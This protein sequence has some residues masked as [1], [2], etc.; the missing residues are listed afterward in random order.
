MPT[1]LP[2]PMQIPGDGHETL[3]KTLSPALLGFGALW[4][5]QVDP[6]HVATSGTDPTDP[7][8]VNDPTLVHSAA[9]THDTPASPFRPVLSSG[10]LSI[11]QVLPFQPSASDCIA[12]TP[13]F[14]T[15]D[16]TAVH[17]DAE[18][19]EIPLSPPKLPGVGVFWIV[20][21]LPFQSSTSGC[22]TPG[23]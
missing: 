4:L 1:V 3:V 7:T 20:Q 11:V 9:E 14:S 6:S 5:V 8:L 23:F 2:T 21:S 19:H 17:V 18:A 12:V 22:C 15:S 13:G 10:T 16:P